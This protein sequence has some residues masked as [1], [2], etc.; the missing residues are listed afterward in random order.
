MPSCGNL[1]LLGER[2]NYKATSDGFID[3]TFTDP[4]DI[5][6]WHR[7]KVDT[8]TRTGSLTVRDEYSVSLI[9]P[10]NTV[11]DIEAS[12][13]WIVTETVSDHVA[14]TSLCATGDT[15]VITDNE[16]TTV[17]EGSGTYSRSETQTHVVLNEVR[18]RSNTNGSSTLIPN[19]CQ[20]EETITESFTD[21]FPP[22]T[23]SG[24]S[25]ST[26]I[27]DSPVIIG[28]PLNYDPSTDEHVFTDRI[29][30]EDWLKYARTVGD[31]WSAD[32]DESC[33]LSGGNGSETIVTTP[34]SESSAGGLELEFFRYR[35]Q[36]P[37]TH[38]GSYYKITYDIVEFPTVGDPFYVSEDLV[39]EWAGAGSGSQDNPS[40]LSP[41]EYIEPSTNGGE[42]RIVN[43]RYTCYRETKYG[44]KPQITGESFTPAAP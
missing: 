42:R 16:I 5:T 37:N 32:A 17:C 29:N 39:Y 15:I 3:G 41:M 44:V 26:T 28:S 31:D 25:T 18:Y 13:N 14:A 34:T 7:Y 22:P 2:L 12:F 23:T 4:F 6:A 27:Q 9:P 21:Y 8:H 35:W 20:F 24:S 30:W 10:I 11:V 40:W 1:V 38:L 36:I 43:I 33:W 19:S